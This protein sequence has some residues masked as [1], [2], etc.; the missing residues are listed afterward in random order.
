[1]ENR[2]G[3]GDRR[4]SRR[5]FCLVKGPRGTGRASV[6]PDKNPFFRTTPL[7]KPYASYAFIDETSFPV[8]PSDANLLHRTRACA[9]LSTVLAC[10]PSERVPVVTRSVTPGRIERLR[11]PPTR[12]AS[13]SA[14]SAGIL[15]PTGPGV[16]VRPANGDA[17]GGGSVR[18]NPPS[19]T[20]RR[21]R[22][23]ATPGQKRLWFFH[24]AP[25]TNGTDDPTRPDL[26]RLDLTPA[27]APFELGLS[28]SVRT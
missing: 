12:V 1:M 22:A 19:V 25:S 2:L 26:T 10:R 14:C 28:V 9:R 15:R 18:S 6:R 4:S 13:A 27:P 17:Y 20:G 8:R 24:L 11:N 3:D 23:N 5:P 21:R 7:E 16:P